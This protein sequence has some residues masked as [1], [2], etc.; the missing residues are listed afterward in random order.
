MNKSL[1]LNIYLFIGLITWLLWPNLIS[2]NSQSLQSI[3]DQASDGEV[4]EIPRGTYDES[5]TIDKAITLVG[6]EDV[7]LQVEENE[8][9]ITILTDHVTIKDLTILY[10]DNMKEQAAL[11]VNGDNN[12]LENLTIQTNSYGIQLKDAHHNNITQVTITGEKNVPIRERK[13]GIDLFQADHNTISHA[14]IS[15]VEDG[16][17]IESSKYNVIHNNKATHS[18]YGYHLMFTRETQ[19]YENESYENISGMMIMGT[20]GTSAYHNN[21]KYNQKNV[22][23]LG[24]L[25]FDVH[26]AIIEKNNIAHNRVGIFVEDA[27]NNEI[28]HNNV[29][30]NFVGLQFK[31]AESNSIHHNA[32]LA[33]V[34][35]GQAEESAHN[36]TN[37]NYWSDHD[38]LDLTG[39]GYSSLT[40][41]IDPFYLHLTDEFPP[42]R[43][44][45][46][47]PGMIFLEKMLQTPAEQQLTDVQPLL[48]NPLTD[49]D[50]TEDRTSILFVVS[51]VLLLISGTIMYMG[52]KQT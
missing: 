6:D 15:Y 49:Y 10:H 3:I 52:V 34:V 4:I 27:H 18:R 48:E 21:L 14:K 1:R 40:Y 20:K 5:I 9:A 28:R 12:E 2:A 24:L 29:R 38:G 50:L 17:Y 31:R 46:Q 37:N 47:S 25:L 33:N 41:T 16:I 23:S 51:S 19:L 8:P 45:F 36:N 30:N 11:Y 39:D 22:Q 26:E 7:I 43:L 35:Q 42:Y 32:F 13:H 44:L